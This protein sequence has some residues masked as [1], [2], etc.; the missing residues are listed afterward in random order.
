[1]QRIFIDEAQPSM[2]LAVTVKDERSNVLF[3]RGAELTEKH[4]GIMRS[5]NV[6]KLVVEGSPVKKKGD[7]ATKALEKRFSSAGGSALALKIR[8]ILKELIE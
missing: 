3:L 8:D 4:I 6:C 5:N 7:E 1:M 2:V